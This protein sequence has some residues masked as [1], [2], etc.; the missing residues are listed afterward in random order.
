M[1]DQLTKEELKR[2]SDLEKSA[3]PTNWI[4]LDFSQGLKKIE[5]IALAVE[6]RNN[7]ASLID[8]A[9]SFI[10]SEEWYALRFKMLRDLCEKHGLL[11]QFCN[12]AANGKEDVFS[13]RSYEDLVL[14]ANHDKEKA[15]KAAKQTAKNMEEMERDL[16]L[17]I[18]E[19][20]K[21]IDHLKYL[22]SESLNHFH[23]VDLNLVKEINQAL[24]E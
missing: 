10:H 1:Q 12:I 14:A 17:K 21:E 6:L 4:G 7:A 22:L 23:K 24:K 3:T 20:E 16:Y 15:I 5:D 19:K 9:K 18:N 13:P 11:D 2:F 8:M